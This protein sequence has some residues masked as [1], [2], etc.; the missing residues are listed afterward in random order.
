MKET[1]KEALYRAFE[2]NV[3]DWLESYDKNW[4]ENFALFIKYKREED[5]L[6]NNEM[7]KVEPK[8]WKCMSDF[9]KNK[10][11]H[12]AGINITYPIIFNMD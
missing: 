3:I 2:E 10:I 4:R 8:C 6:F 11:C 9:E 1:I 12:E 7:N 5:K